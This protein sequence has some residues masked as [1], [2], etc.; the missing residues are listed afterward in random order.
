MKAILF[1]FSPTEPSVQ[2]TRDFAELDWTVVASPEDVA[3]AAPGTAIYV[4]S[5]RTCKPATGEALRRYGDALR[6]MHFTSAGIDGG[7]AMGIPDGVMVTNS[8]GVRSGNVSEHALLL[9]L[10]LARALPVWQASQRTH[11]WLRQETVPQVK[12][13]QNAVV[14]ILG[15][16]SIGREL[17]RKLKGLDARP[18]AVSRTLDPDEHVTQVFPRDRLHEAL[19]MSDAL[20][21]CTSGGDETRH[22]I[23]AAEFA[24]LRPGALVVNIARGSIIDEAALMAA[25]R[26]GHI[27]GAGLDVAQTEP[28]PAEHPLWDMANV[29]LSPHVAGSGSEGYL[30]QRKL[31]GEN[32]RRFKAGEPLL[33][34]CRSPAGYG[35]V[36]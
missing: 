20:A 29:I 27:G 15:R 19:A 21:I 35:A 31:F 24:A 3:R 2:L 32:L 30:H 6:W 10:A 23:G 25:L 14:C 12:T 5:N 9:L 36:P 17:A 1:P 18:I 4:T 33:N 11:Q 7:I 13:L 34:L 28:L 16:G 8:T 26:S 22:M